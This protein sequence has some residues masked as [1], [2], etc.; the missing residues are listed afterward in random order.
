MACFQ[1]DLK[2][3]VDLR[4]DLLSI[5]IN[6]QGERLGTYKSVGTDKYEPS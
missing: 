1:L 2:K 4:Q 6:Q 5:S 3:K